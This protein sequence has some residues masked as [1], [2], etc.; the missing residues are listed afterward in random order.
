MWSHDTVSL[1]DSP[2]VFLFIFEGHVAA[3]VLNAEFL[4][5]TCRVSFVMEEM[6]N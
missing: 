6:R 1:D 2:I 3:I 5:E 4:E